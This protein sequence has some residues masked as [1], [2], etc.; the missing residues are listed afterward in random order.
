[1]VV[2]I[3]S[4]VFLL[5][6]AANGL[7]NATYVD[8]LLLESY[9]RTDRSSNHIPVII[10]LR[11]GK[12]GIST[13]QMLRDSAHLQRSFESDAPQGI[14]IERRM[15]FLPVLSAAVHPERLQELINQTEVEAI[16]LDQ[17]NEPLLE[18]STD[19]V[20]PS[21]YNTIL[22]GASDWTVAVLD[23]GVDA[24]HSFLQATESNTKIVAEACF[25]TGNGQTLGTSICPNGVLSSSSS[26]S[27][28][29]CEL[30]GCDHGTHVAGIVAGQKGI[31]SFAGIA[32]GANLISIQV[33]TRFD[34]ESVC[35]G[36]EP[37]IRAYD[38][39]IIRALEH[40]FDLS[41]THKIAAVNLSIGGGYYQGMCDFHPVKTAI[42][43]LRSV[44][45]P[46]VVAAGN[47]GFTNALSAPAC[48]SSAITIGATYD[49]GTNQDLETSYSNESVALDLYAPGHNIVSSTLYGGYSTK[50]GTSMAA[51]HVSGAIAVLKEAAPNVTI[52]QL[53]FILKNTGINIVSRSGLMRRRIS[54]TDAVRELT[55]ANANDAI[56]QALSD[57]SLCIPINVSTGDLMTV[58]D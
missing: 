41:R 33:F 57:T 25:S 22:S 29:P 38:S 47:N 1:M 16:F 58:C 46:T 8:P 32:S 49:S 24:T 30:T 42:D 56:N 19:I 51:P 27:G 23:S 26:G 52:D 14:S 37:C 43:L 40:V 13:R 21:Q 45:I 53:E 9:N 28:E 11:G 18:Q 12:S 5:L 20:F 34:S 3:R 31:T 2:L 50:S 35:N 15:K 54:L 39:D 48:I 10:K 7:A 36:R 55:I 6:A 4:V 17:L 44:N